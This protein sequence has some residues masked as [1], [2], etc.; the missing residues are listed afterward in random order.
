MVSSHPFL[1]PE[2]GTLKRVRKVK[3]S[4]S[5]LYQLLKEIITILTFHGLFQISLREMAHIYIYISVWL[6]ISLQKKLPVVNPDVRQP[7]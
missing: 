3:E 4:S 1:W 6:E 5:Y 7:R 2:Y